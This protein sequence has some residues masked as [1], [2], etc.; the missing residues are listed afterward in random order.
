[1]LY[2]QL[3][4]LTVL[5]A[6]QAALAPV[7]L[8]VTPDIHHPLFESL[9]AQGIEIRQQQGADLGERMARALRE[10]LKQSQFAVLVGS[11]CPAMSVGYLDRACRSLTDGAEVVLGPAE[12]GGYVLIGA[13]HSYEPLFE[14]ISW[15]TDQ[16]LT[17]T[18]QRLAMLGCRTVELDT[19]WDLDRP[20]DLLRWRRG[21]AR[22]P[23]ILTPPA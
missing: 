9:A 12:D 6:E 7:Q 17:E 16:V 8:Q 5:R 1:M 15:S 14:G 18:R 2:G 10:A 23:D 20:E 11:D 22:Q 13:R 21:P 19:L 3:L 4:R